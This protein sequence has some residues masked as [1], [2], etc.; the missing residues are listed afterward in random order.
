MAVRAD[1]EIKMTSGNW[2]DA[3]FTT[4]FFDPRGPSGARYP[5]IGYTSPVAVGAASPHL[6]SGSETI[7]SVTQAEI[8]TQD[9]GH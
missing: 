1:G 3:V 6:A 5:I 8:N 2:S 7:S 9:L 4:G